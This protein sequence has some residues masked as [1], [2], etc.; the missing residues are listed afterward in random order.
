MALEVAFFRYDFLFQNGL[1]AQVLI[2][3]SCSKHC[4][5]IIIFVLNPKSFP[6]SI[7]ILRVK[8]EVV[9]C[10]TQGC[11]DAFALDLVTD[12][13]LRSRLFDVF[14]F[15]ALIPLAENF[16]S[17]STNRSSEYSDSNSPC[18]QRF[19]NSIVGLLGFLLI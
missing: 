18:R 19:N 11:E 17:I 14:E 12:V 16:S 10:G 3:L 6:F 13:L 2:G 5:V 15:T 1:S 7:L 8:L 9:S 4:F